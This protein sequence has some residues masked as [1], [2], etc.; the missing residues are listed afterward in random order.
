MKTFFRKLGAFLTGVRVWTV[1][2]FVLLL[3]VYFVGALVMVAKRMPGSVDPEGKVLIL[4]VEGLVLDQEVF[5]DDITAALNRPEEEQIQ[6]RDLVR[7]IRSAA[8][9]ERLAGVLLDFGK[10]RFAGF[11]TALLIA[12]ELAALRESG[13][14]VIAYSESIGTAGY[15]MAAQA[16]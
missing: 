5:S 6:T 12:E 1:N 2:L 9:D 14:P 3:L 15:L 16:E 13:K 4:Q 8:E 10:A 7:L 11:S